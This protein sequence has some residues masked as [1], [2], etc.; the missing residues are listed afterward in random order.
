MMGDPG[1]ETSIEVSN[2][3]VKTLY[4]DGED[5]ASIADRASIVIDKDG[6]T[7]LTVEYPV[8]SMTLSGD[9]PADFTPSIDINFVKACIVDFL[10]SV[11]PS[12]LEGA[13]LSKAGWGSESTGQLILEHLKDRV[14][15]IHQ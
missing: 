6:S 11:D 9:I 10:N 4:M 5:L 8:S 12:D 15:A 7:K 1:R 13:A 14:N 3:R 2:G